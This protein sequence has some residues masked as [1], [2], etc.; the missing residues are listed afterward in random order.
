ME[1]LASW[2]QGPH[3]SSGDVLPSHIVV[4]YGSQERAYL[5]STPGFIRRASGILSWAV[6]KFCLAKESGQ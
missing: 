1:A 5:P 2:V 4:E 6:L 3:F